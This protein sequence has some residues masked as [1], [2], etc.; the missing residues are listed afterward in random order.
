MWNLYGVGSLE[1]KEAQD[2]VYE[3]LERIG[4]TESET[5]PTHAFLHLVEELGETSRSLLH[6]ETERKKFENRTEAG[7]L[8]KEVGDILWQTMKLASY[9]DIDLE[10]AFK[11]VLEKNRN[12]N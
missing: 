6:R 2:L 10:E 5:E 9:L 8:K 12:K 4:Y 7:T 11:E 1:I 3:H